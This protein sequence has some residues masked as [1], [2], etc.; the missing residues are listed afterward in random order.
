MNE[1]AL[2]E[3]T[4]L[5]YGAPVVM[6]VGRVHEIT[7]GPTDPANESSGGWKSDSSRHAPRVDAQDR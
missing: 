2:S 5:T 4:D 7:A 3:T 6:P 1:Q